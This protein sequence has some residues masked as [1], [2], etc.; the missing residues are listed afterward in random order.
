MKS[1]VQQGYRMPFKKTT[2]GWVLFFISIFLSQAACDPG[3]IFG[4]GQQ[5]PQYVV[6]DC[7][8]P[9]LNENFS[10]IYVGTGSSSVVQIMSPSGTDFTTFGFPTTTLP[11]T[12]D[13]TGIVNG[14]NRDCKQT[15]GTT[16]LEVYSCYDNSQ[17]T[18]TISMQIGTKF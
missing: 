8:S 1:L 15:F 18:C 12:G 16:D 6:T 13:S 9:I 11:I 7:T 17:L 5:I 4:P 2:L 3:P 10:T 14:K